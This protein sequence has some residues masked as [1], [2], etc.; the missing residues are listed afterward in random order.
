M[1]GGRAGSSRQAGR[2]GSQVKEV[3]WLARRESIPELQ[4]VLRGVGRKAIL[5]SSPLR[6]RIHS[7]SR[8][9]S[10]VLGVP[11]D[12][13]LYRRGRL[14]VTLG[15]NTFGLGFSA[16]PKCRGCAGVCRGRRP[17]PRL[18]GRQ[19]PNPCPLGG[20]PMSIPQ[21]SQGTTAPTVRSPYFL[22]LQLLLSPAVDRSPV[23]VK[24]PESNGLSAHL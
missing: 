19:L 7:T 10:C 13:R 11:T 23:V 5:Y 24:R 21:P 20:H 1:V 3:W 9:V 8:D 18:V 16:R 14:K 6:L 22:Q 17:Y 4:S 12:Y 15:R 2:T